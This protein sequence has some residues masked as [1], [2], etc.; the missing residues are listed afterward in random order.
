V[1]VAQGGGEG[2]VVLPRIGLPFP[3]RPPVAAPPGSVP[4]PTV[5]TAPAA[6]AAPAGQTA[7]GGPVQ[8]NYTPTPNRQTARE[9][10]AKQAGDKLTF[11]KTKEMSSLEDKS[12]DDF[13]AIK[14]VQDF[15]KADLVF[16][17]AQKAAK[18]DTKAADLNLVYAFAT[19]MDPGSVVRDQE[20]GMVVATQGASD[21]VKALVA[22]VS[23]KSGLSLDAKKALIDEMGTRHSAYKESHDAFATAFEEIA[24]RRGLD[25]RNVVTRVVVEKPKE[26]KPGDPDIIDVNPNGKRK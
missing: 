9:D 20:T 23:G 25:P 19:M 13:N 15:R 1:P 24:T 5:S 17:S 4:F 8:P 6:P 2:E 10:A 7:P 12:R 26:A 21:R 11:E 14:Q 16:Q 3:A 22:S 18:T